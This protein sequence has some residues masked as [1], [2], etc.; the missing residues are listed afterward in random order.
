MVLISFYL[1]PDYSSKEFRQGAENPPLKIEL[2]ETGRVRFQSYKKRDSMSSEMEA[3]MEGLAPG[4]GSGQGD[5]ENQEK[6]EKEKKLEDS[7]RNLF[8]NCPEAREIILDR[9]DL[10]TALACRLVCKE[11]RVTVNCYRKLWAKINKVFSI[12]V[13]IQL[14]IF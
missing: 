10:E 11:W 9:V 13:N 4:E 6:R 3:G 2:E 14:A 8:R 12:A 7:A 5:R 1:F